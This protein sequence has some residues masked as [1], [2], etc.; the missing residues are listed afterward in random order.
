MRAVGQE[1]YGGPEVLEVADIERPELGNHDVLVRV[2]AAGVDAGTWHLMTGRPYLIRLVGFGLR[3]PSQPVR[4]LDFAGIVEA[5]GAHAHGWAPGDRVFGTGEGAW[6]EYV[7]ADPQML[8]ALP[9]DVSMEEGAAVATS[10]CTA[11]EA[12]RDYGATGPGDRVLVLGAG[13]GVGS[14]AVQIAKALGAEVTGVCSRTKGD[15]VRSWGAD[16]VLDYRSEEPTRADRRYDVIIDLAGNRP[17]SALRRI[18][19]E[20]GR[21]VLAGGEDGDRFT[22]GMGRSLR[23][24]LATLRGRAILRPMISEPTPGNLATLAGMLADGR[25]RAR[26]GQTFALEDAAR[27]MRAW[28]RRE[29]TGK[30]VLRLTQSV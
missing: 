2:A 23:A 29:I 20:G 18:L 6:A 27:A 13:G 3:A 14:F 22:G 25:I 15:A 26:V 9:P 21:L 10:G 17:L 1:S 11:L 8:A 5:V 19:A 12:V 28:E 4:G 7:A 24:G 16:H 30:A